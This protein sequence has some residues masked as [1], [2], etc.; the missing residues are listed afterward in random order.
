[1]SLTITGIT[2]TFEIVTFD[3]LSSFINIVKVKYCSVFLNFSF[4]FPF[5]YNIKLFLKLFYL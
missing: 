3:Y 1:M 2:Q 5:D 4:I